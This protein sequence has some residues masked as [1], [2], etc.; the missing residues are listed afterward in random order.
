METGNGFFK[1]TFI[2]FIILIVVGI[3]IRFIHVGKTSDKKTIDNASTDDKSSGIGDLDFVE[4]STTPY[5]AADML[6]YEFSIPS[7]TTVSTDQEGTTIIV[8]DKE[9]GLQRVLL[10]LSYEGDRRY[11]P[12]AY[13]QDIIAPKIGASTTESTLME[14]EVPWYHVETPSMEWSIAPVKNGT[15]LIVTEANKVDNDLVQV[16]LQSFTI[17]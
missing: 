11:T 10:Y 8:K 6:S 12:E 13:F 4:G 14:G 7:V 15:W 2:I 16:I 17:K 3:G 1:W 5:K 9:T